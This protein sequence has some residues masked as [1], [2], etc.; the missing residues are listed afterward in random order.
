MARIA[1]TINREYH[2]DS[3][4]VRAIECE[5]NKLNPHSLNSVHSNLKE[6]PQPNLP[7]MLM[8]TLAPDGRLRTT[9]P[10]WKDQD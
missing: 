9:H 1:P 10:K 4:V 8:Q 6:D 2:V 5:L 3:L 7:K